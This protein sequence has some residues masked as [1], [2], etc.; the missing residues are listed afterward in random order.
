MLY[1]VQE[2]LDDPASWMNVETKLT[3]FAWPKLL[4]PSILLQHTEYALLVQVS[5]KRM[6]MFNIGVSIKWEW[7]LGTEQESICEKVSFVASAFGC[8]YISYDTSILKTCTW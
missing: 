3:S 5:R 4:S 7:L 8:G 1:I 2:L 6:A